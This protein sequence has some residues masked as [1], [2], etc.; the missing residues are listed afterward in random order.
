[1]SETSTLLPPDLWN[2]RLF[3]GTWEKGP[4]AASAVIEP[5]TGK[6]LGKVAMANAE[7]INSASLT[8]RGI[9]NDW[10]NRPYDERATVLR[11]AAQ[12]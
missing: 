7:T 11:R 1:M 2:E 9:Q 8:A 4:L 10:F 6:T 5:A 12:K 3:S